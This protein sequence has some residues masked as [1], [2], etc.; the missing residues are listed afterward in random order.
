VRQDAMGKPWVVGGQVSFII[1]E[2]ADNY[3]D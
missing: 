2:Y 1:F 3:I